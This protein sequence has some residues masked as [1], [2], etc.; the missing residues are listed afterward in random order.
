MLFIVVVVVVEMNKDG[1]I[2]LVAGL[3]SSWY[4]WFEKLMLRQV[5]RQ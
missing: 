3:G 1:W 5:D 4:R 2:V